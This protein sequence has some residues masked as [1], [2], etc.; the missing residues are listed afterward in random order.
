MKNK[1]LL[2]ITLCFITIN[3]I[4][5]GGP[6]AGLSSNLIVFSEDGQKFYLILN[7]IRQNDLPETNIKVTNLTNQYYS[8][9]IIFEDKTIPMI[10]KKMLFVQD[11]RFQPLE[12]NYHIVN[13]KSGERALR[14][15]VQMPM[16]L[17]PATEPGVRVLSYN[18]I[19][20]P[21]ISSTTTTTTTTINEGNVYSNN[22][23][24]ANVNVN[25]GGIGIGMDVNINDPYMNGSSTSTTYST[26][27][28]T[29]TTGGMTTT[30]NTTTTDYFMSG[31][32]GP[33]GC[34]GWPMKDVD[35]A[36]A[37]TSISSKSFE[38]SKLTTAKQVANSNC[39]TADQVKQIMKLFSFEDSKLDF[40]KYAYTHTFDVGNYFKVNDAFEF[41]SSIDELNNAIGR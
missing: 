34:N 29:T 5:Q 26:T 17:A 14:M 41:E 31:Y 11:D 3:A 1:F 19:A 23:T 12:V 20:K 24:G 16:T 32:N 4:A 8:A 35:F 33:E 21:Q 9:K 27:T 6:N 7:G 36:S 18:T 10:E 40:A 39:L 30:G 28:T 25:V 2:F 15:Y 22:N 13:T 37:K 38:D